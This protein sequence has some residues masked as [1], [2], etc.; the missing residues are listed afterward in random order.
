MPYDGLSYRL[1]TGSHQTAAPSLGQHTDE[2]LGDLL[3]LSA[4]ELDELRGAAIIA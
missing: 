4:T 3:G 1:E 2:V